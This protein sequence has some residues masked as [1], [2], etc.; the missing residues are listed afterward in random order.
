MI[1][2]RMTV[3]VKQARMQELLEFLKEDRKRAVRS[4]S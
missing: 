4:K 2:Q 1:V 3:N